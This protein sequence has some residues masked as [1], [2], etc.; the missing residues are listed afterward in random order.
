MFVTMIV[1]KA[2]TMIVDRVKD[3]GLMRITH[4]LTE[5]YPD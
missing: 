1:T 3:F 4:T 5:S 2:C